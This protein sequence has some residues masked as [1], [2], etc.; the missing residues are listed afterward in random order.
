MGFSTVCEKYLVKFLLATPTSCATHLNLWSGS[1]WLESW[2]EFMDAASYSLG[3]CRNHQC[4]CLA[5]KS[6]GHYYQSSLA[7]LLQFILASLPPVVDSTYTSHLVRGGSGCMETTVATS[8]SHTKERTDSPLVL[9]TWREPFLH[10]ICSRFHPWG[11][12]P[13]RSLQSTE[14]CKATNQTE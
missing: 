7:S 2:I 3:T 5:M 8:L 10:V 6:W 1:G 13:S 4:Y 12:S 14:Q 11:P 9:S